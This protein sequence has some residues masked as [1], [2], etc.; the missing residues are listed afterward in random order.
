MKT[1]EMSKSDWLKWQK[2]VIR[3]EMKEVS[4]GANTSNKGNVC[5]SEENR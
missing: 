1:V 2:E 4:N 3:A 5:Y